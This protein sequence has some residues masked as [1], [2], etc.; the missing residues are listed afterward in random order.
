MN[1]KD[2]QRQNYIVDTANEFTK[3]KISK[4]DFMRKMGMAGIGFSAFSAGMLLLNLGG[5]SSVDPV[6]APPGGGGRVRRRGQM[7]GESRLG[8]APP[9]GG[10]AWMDMAP[11][12][13]ARARAAARTEMGS[14]S[15]SPSS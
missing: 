14:S 1:F 12:P 7:R 4:R 11:S 3:R 5:A 10:G 2:F 15:V 6:W 8:A 13:G 9:R